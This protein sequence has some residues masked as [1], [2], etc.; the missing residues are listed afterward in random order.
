MLLLENRPYTDESL[1]PL[2]GDLP[3]FHTEATVAIDVDRTV[4]RVEHVVARAAIVGAGL[5]VDYPELAAAQKEAEQ[6]GTFDITRHIA[7]TLTPEAVDQFNARFIGYSGQGIRDVSDWLRDPTYIRSLGPEDQ[8]KVL[9]MHEQARYLLYP[10]S[11]QLD[12]ALEGI[13]SFY[14][15]YAINRPWQ[16]TKLAGLAGNGLRGF[17]HIMGSAEKGPTMATYKD[18]ETDMFDMVALDSSGSPL[19]RVLAPYL[20]LIDDKKTA[21]KNSPE[22]VR[23]VWLRRPEEPPLPSQIRGELPAGADTVP[24]LTF[25]TISGIIKRSDWDPANSAARKRPEIEHQVAAYV[26]A[27]FFSDLANR[28]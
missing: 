16:R 7:K 20:Y 3:I 26:P 21:S 19:A 23:F 27:C 6:D 24:D 14:L 10:D 17:A 11:H 22:G 12:K 13:P 18:P 25:D 15:T 9:H 2:P 28:P 1:P 4:S 8:A 5:G